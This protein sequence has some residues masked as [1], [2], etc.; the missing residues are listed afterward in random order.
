MCISKT[1]SAIS[2][3]LFCGSFLFSQSLVDVAKKEKERRESL[4]GIP[5]IIVTNQ[6]LKRIPREETAVSVSPKTPPQK[7]LETIPAPKTP[8]QKTPPAKQVE[9]SDQ[10]DQID[11]T[12]FTLNYA[13]RIL[14]STQFVENAQFALNKPDG[15]FAEIGEFGFLDLEIEVI[16]RQGSD[17]S[18][19][20]RRLQEGYQSM[21]MNYGVFVEHRGEWEFIG[22]SDGN[23]SPNIFDL[24]DIRSTNK[25]RIIFKDF[26]QDMWPAKP[27][28]LHDS[29]Y[30]MGID[31]VESLHR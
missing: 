1:A 19:Y 27:Y 14:E 15:Q 21:T 29:E 10:A 13:T 12:S 30:S 26:T 24:G 25:I 31:A 7:S 3:L 9:I 16:N 23:S 17:L 2:I 22:F 20:A 8:A 18:I 28:K 4:K 5:S 11:T 6:D